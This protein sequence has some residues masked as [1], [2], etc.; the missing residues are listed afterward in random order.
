MM[1]KV[2]I[3]GAMGAWFYLFTTENEQN[4]LKKLH[5]QVTERLDNALQEAEVNY[6][7]S[8]VKIVILRIEFRF[9]PLAY[10]A[11]DR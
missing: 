1:L 7:D 9:F 10:S 3:L 11:A 6:Q 8:I 4:S 5:L 2:W